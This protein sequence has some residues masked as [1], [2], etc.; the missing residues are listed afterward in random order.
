[1]MPAKPKPE[2]KRENFFVSPEIEASVDYLLTVMNAESKTDVYVSSVQMAAF[3]AAE[4]QRGST[5][6]VSEPT[7]NEYRRMPLPWIEKSQPEWNFLVSRPHKWRKQLYIKG[8]KIPA[9]TV[10]SGLISNNLSPEAAAENW[11]IPIK[12]VLESI[13]YCELNRDL[14]KMEA[15]EERHLLEAAGIICEPEDS[16]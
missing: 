15:L 10:W 6:Y 13:N 11:D 9:S 1:M 7:T 16:N 5:F 12:A 3:L 8:T 4:C 2:K 14:L